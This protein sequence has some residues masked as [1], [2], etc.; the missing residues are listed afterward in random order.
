MVKF[1]QVGCWV[2][3]WLEISFKENI[4]I[5]VKLIGCIGI[6]DVR[7]S[8]REKRRTVRPYAYI[9]VHQAGV[10]TLT[11]AQIP[12][13]NS[14]FLTHELSNEYPLIISAG[15]DGSIFTTDLR[16]SSVGNASGSV[17]L[18]H[19]RG[20]V[21][22]TDYSMYLTAPIVSESDDIVSSVSFRKNEYRRVARFSEFKSGIWSI[23]CSTNH[24]FIAVGGF[25]G[26]V[27]VVNPIS[28]MVSRQKRKNVSF[29]SKKKK[30]YTN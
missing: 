17:M 12:E 6:Y 19:V 11:W 30:V 4:F 21:Y 13:I 10:R 23:A 22:D 8:I 26:H 25:N 28:I 18:D 14:Q 5:N 1:K 29:C 3:K 9:N 20:Y 15:Y 27:E 24:P 7:N 2:F 16:D